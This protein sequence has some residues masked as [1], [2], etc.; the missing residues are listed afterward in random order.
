V[1]TTF[2]VTFGVW[3]TTNCPIREKD[4]GIAYNRI[5][6]VSMSEQVGDAEQIKVFRTIDAEIGLKKSDPEGVALR[7]GVLE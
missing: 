2:S 7:C 6:Y 4:T 3:P 1:V 5:S